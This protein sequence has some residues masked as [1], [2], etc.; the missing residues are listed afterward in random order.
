MRSA[1]GVTVD[2]TVSGAQ[3]SSGDANG[4]DISNIEQLIGSDYNDTLTGDTNNN[5]LWG[6]LLNDTLNGG[7]GNDT[8]YGEAGDDTLNGDAG[9]DILYGG[10][11]TNILNGGN[12]QDEI[13]ITD[14][15]ADDTVDGGSGL[16]DILNMSAISGTLAIDLSAQTVSG[17]AVSNKTISNI[18]YAKGSAQDDVITGTIGRNKLW[19]NDGADT[20]Y[21]G[22]HRDHL[23]GGNGADTLDGG[24]HTDYLTGGAGADIFDYNN[25]LDSYTGS[26]DEIYD[27][28][29]G[30]DRIDLQ[31][32]VSDIAAFGDLSI[33]LDSG[34]TYDVTDASGSN[35]AIKVTLT[36]GSLTAGDFI[37]A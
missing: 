23:Y 21:G 34:T 17:S 25:V 24:L 9:N 31:A 19:G 33:T 22:Y 1:A 37:F 7:T 15:T 6:G 29:V 36:G 11:G 20:L 3:T 32:L 5:I 14:D 2:L 8:L 35:F 10:A 28:E 13:H 26:E 12:G 30:T 27:F 4:D 16:A 18:E